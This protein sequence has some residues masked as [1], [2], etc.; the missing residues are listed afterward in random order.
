VVHPECDIRAWRRV[1]ES[2]VVDVGKDACNTRARP[3][4]PVFVVKRGVTGKV[5]DRFVGSLCKCDVTERGEIA[6]RVAFPFE[7]EA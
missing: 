3:V 6:D 1:V 4:D 7:L 5:D 2:F